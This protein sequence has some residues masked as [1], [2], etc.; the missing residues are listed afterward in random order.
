MIIK[1]IMI[2]RIDASADFIK[3]EDFEKTSFLMKFVP[4]E[5]PGPGPPKTR[6]KGPKAALF[7]Q[8][9]GFRGVKQ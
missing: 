2:M 1:V 6:Q 9:V 3:I 5:G 4:P 7:D 8:K